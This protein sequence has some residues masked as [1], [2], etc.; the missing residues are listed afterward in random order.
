MNFVFIELPKF[1]K[2]EKELETHFDKWLYFLKHL[3]SFKTIPEIL[4][5]DIFIEA[6]KTAEI[7]I[8]MLKDEESMAK[9][10][11]YSKLNE[12]EILELKKNLE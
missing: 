7:A 2:E 4:N 11:K 6:F 10:I 8:E 9:I 12:K 5:E 1:S 3:D